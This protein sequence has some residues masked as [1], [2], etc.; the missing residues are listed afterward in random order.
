MALNG[1]TLGDL[2]R[3]SVDAAIAAHPDANEAQR[4]AVFR[5]IGN[6]IVTHVLTA[7]VVVASVSAVTPGMGVSGPGTGTLV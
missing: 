1:N 7:Q 5:A 3:T 6:A 2:I 4:Q